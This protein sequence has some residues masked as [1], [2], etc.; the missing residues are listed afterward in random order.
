MVDVCSIKDRIVAARK[1][2]NLTQREVAAMQKQQ[3]YNISRQ[4]SGAVYPSLQY[5]AFLEQQGINL[6]WLFSG[7]GEMFRETSK[8]QHLEMA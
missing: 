2:L 4:E 6:N 7:K 8:I 5:L 3:Q 1:L